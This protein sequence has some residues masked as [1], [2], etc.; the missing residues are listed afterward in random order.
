MFRILVKDG[1]NTWFVRKLYDIITYDKFNFTYFNYNE[2][3][4]II[5]IVKR[6]N[7]EVELIPY[8]NN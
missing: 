3:E 4:K 7:M 1:K 8:D 6:N 5:E 2:I